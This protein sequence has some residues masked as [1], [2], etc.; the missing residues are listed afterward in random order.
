[1]VQ[2][3]QIPK[4]WKY[5][6]HSLRYKAIG[7]YKEPS[8]IF[9]TDCKYHIMIQIPW[10]HQQCSC[11]GGQ[12]WNHWFGLKVGYKCACEAMFCVSEYILHMIALL[13]CCFRRWRCS[14]PYSA[15][16]TSSCSPAPD[17]VQNIRRWWCPKWTVGGQFQVFCIATV[18]K[19]MACHK[20]Q[21]TPRHN[22]DT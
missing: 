5:C 17:R 18:M 3:L 19:Q 12:L 2:C 6:W 16:S 15:A 22:D 11:S 21:R 9:G 1:M 14:T 20:L 10:N 8:N 4:K 7:P 13:T